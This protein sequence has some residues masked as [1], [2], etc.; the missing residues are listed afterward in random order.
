MNPCGPT[1]LKPR[2]T[3][4]RIRSLVSGKAGRL[5]FW[6]VLDQ[7]LFSLTNF[8]TA[9]IIGRCCGPAELGVYVLAFSVVMLSV[10]LARATLVSPYVVVSQELHGS[11]LQSMRGTLLIA[12]WTLG[13]VSAVVACVVAF[14]LE[15][16]GIAFALA[17]AMPAALFRDFLRRLSIAELQVKSAVGLDWVIGCLQIGL[18]CSLWRSG[19][20]TAQSAL[21]ACSAIWAV[22]AVVWLYAMRGQ[23]RIQAREFHENFAHIWP[24]GRWVGMSQM[25][26]TTQAFVLPWIL[27]VVHSIELAGAY[28]ACWT[29]VQIA[30]PA[31]EGLGNLL[32]PALARSAS[33]GAWKSLL[34]RVRVA[35]CVFGLM[36]AGLLS[37][38]LLLGGQALMW[39]YGAGYAQ[40]YGVLVLLTLAAAAINL[41]IPA[42]KALTQLGRAETNFWITLMSLCLTVG[43]AGTLLY[44]LGEHGAALGL[45]VGAA[46][47]TVFR[48]IQ[49]RNSHPL[50]M[51]RLVTP[52]GAF[53]ESLTSTGGRP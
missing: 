28:G 39:I 48:W 52:P 13:S 51:N 20:L 25:I 11:R 17:L 19:Q 15:S 35:T 33:Q 22:V 1:N 6:A 37:F 34:Y 21:M 42:S 10:C 44:L 32:S 41:G 26:S 7:G 47:A 3:V 18:L 29:V 30:S 46:C 36:M 53:A 45:I 31:I 2:P 4:A 8:L 9:V 38:V 43:A 12:I 50:T 23:F 5:G 24:I 16:G 40:H 49:L 27:A 14:A